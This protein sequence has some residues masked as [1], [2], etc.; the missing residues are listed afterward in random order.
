[1]K[2]RFYVAA[3]D[4]SKVYSFSTL[5]KRERFLAV[6]D[7]WH[8]AYASAAVVKYAPVFFKG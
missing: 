3:D 8:M 6:H 2:R 5:Q 7:G 1:M 4:N